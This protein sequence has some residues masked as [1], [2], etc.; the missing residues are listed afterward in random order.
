MGKALPVVLSL[1]LIAVL[2]ATVAGCDL[3][4]SGN[5]NKTEQSSGAADTVKGIKQKANSAA[6]EA[7]LRIIDAAIEAYQAENGEP[8]ASISQLS[9]YF[10]RG[11]P[12]DPAG[13]TYYITT[14]NG[15][16]KAAVR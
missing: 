14:E 13:G 7:N 6:R 8:P 15:E 12:S 4:S 11:V 16:T 9:Q 10:S 1:L 3:L 2:M 5:S